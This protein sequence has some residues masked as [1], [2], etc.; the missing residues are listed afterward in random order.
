[1]IIKRYIFTFLHK[2]VCCGYSVES[3]RRGGGDSNEY[4]QFVLLWRNNDDHP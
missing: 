3:P 4:P 2:N 1:M